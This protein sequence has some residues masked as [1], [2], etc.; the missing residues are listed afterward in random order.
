MPGQANQC[1][2]Y[3]LSIPS[4]FCVLLN[5]I[6]YHKLYLRKIHFRLR[7]MSRCRFNRGGIKR[8]TA[9]GKERGSDSSSCSTTTSPSRTT[10]S[11]LRALFTSNTLHRVSQIITTWQY[12]RITAKQPPHEVRLNTSSVCSISPSFH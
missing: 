4:L 5:H 8:C 1:P 6:G 2:C 11:S 3:A 12:L 7:G 9:N 10:K